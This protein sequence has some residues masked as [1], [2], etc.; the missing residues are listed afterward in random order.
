MAVTYPH[1]FLR[2]VAAGTLPGPEAWSWSLSLSP[3]FPDA[4]DPAPATV[5]A[6]VVTAVQTFHAATG[7]TNAATRLTTIKLN[8]IGV[9]G[10]YMNETNTVQHDFATPGIAGAYSGAAMPNQVALAVTLRT[11]N[12]RGLAK[13]GRSRTWRRA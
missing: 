3:N 2:L 4:T 6:A 1:P 12:R 5:P 7:I 13:V 8:R 11:R 10:H 9:D